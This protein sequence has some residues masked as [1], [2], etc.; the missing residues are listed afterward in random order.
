MEQLISYVIFI[1]K[2]IGLTLQLLAGGIIIGTFLGVVFSILRYNNIVIFFIN[3]LISILRGTPLILQLSFIY[4]AVPGVIGMKMS[5]LTAGILAFGI[6]ASAYIAEILRAGIQSLPSGQF[7]A[8]KT[9]KIPTFYMW[10]DIILPQVIRNIFPAMLNEIITLLKETAIVSI[11]GGVDIMRSAE[12]VASR[13]FTY[14]MPLCVAACYY[15]GLVLLIE[16]V[17]KKFEKKVS[18]VNN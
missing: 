2:G 9:L 12:M 7:E 13:H 1:G 15:Y 5:I 11:I 17:G 6:N 10:K 8:A 18:H 3:K 14:F 16:Y 4:F